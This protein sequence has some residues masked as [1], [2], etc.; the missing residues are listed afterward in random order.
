MITKNFIV[1]L[2]SSNTIISYHFV[3]WILAAYSLG[4]ELKNLFLMILSFSN[5]SM[6]HKRSLT[7]QAIINYNVVSKDSYYIRAGNE[8][9]RNMIINSK[10]AYKM[11]KILIFLVM[12]I[13]WMDYRLQIVYIRKSFE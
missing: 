2:S 7:L 13:F 4:W 11:F 6:L 9:R 3:K 5:Y 1:H 10:I 8:V 12:L